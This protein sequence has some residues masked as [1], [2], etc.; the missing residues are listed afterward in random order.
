MEDN[1]LIDEKY[2]H[3]D[4]EYDSKEDLLKYLTETMLKD[5]IIKD[6]FYENLMER[7]SK[8]P[9]G[10]NTGDIKVAIPHTNPEHVKRA[11][12]SIATLKKPI[13]FKNMENST[14]DIDADL[15]FMLAVDNPEKQVP[16]LV[17]LM[18]IF[19]QKE[20]LEEIKNSK[21][22]SEIKKIMEKLLED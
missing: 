5:D 19:S 6:T 2:I 12:I 21:D 8:Y 22:K 13:R 15:V 10:L 3:L 11:A 16:L 9:T 4:S 18:S 1:I 20:K 7:E 14:Q 17:K